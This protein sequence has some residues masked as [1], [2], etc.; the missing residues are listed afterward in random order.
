MV[1][2][3]ILGYTESWKVGIFTVMAFGHNLTGDFARLQSDESSMDTSP[4]TTVN[5]D[6]DDDQS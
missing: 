2:P 6:N 1:P 3:I 5:A 4:M